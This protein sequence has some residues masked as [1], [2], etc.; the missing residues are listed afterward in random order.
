MGNLLHVC[1][2]NAD[3]DAAQELKSAIQSL[4]FVRLTAEV[5]SPEALA[6]AL[7]E[8][9][10]NLVFF[11]LD[12]DVAAVVEVIDQVSTRYP[13]LALIAISHE[14]GPEAILAPMRAGCDQ[15]VCEPIDPADLA[16][17]VG[18]VASKRLLSQPKSRCICLTGA[19]GGAGATSLA[20]NLALEIAHLT[21]KECALVDL[22]LQFGDV[23]INFDSEP[24]YTLY[25]LA[26]AGADLD[27]TILTSTLTKLP[28]KVALL[29]RPEMIE[30]HEAVT[31]D[32]IHRVI[33]LLT[34]NYENVIIDL[35]RHMDPCAAAALVHADLVLI[36]C[37]LLVPSVRNA[38]RYFNA[39]IQMG[40]PEERLQIVVNRGDSRA[41]GRLTV[42]DIEE[43]SRKP[44]YACIPNDYQFVARS[45]DFGRPIAALD[46]NSPVRA[47]IRKMARQITVGPGSEKREK[48][49]RRGF[50][51]R[52]LA[53]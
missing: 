35:P 22:D 51:S 9:T 16:T 21:D 42:K 33:E 23:A 18:R 50:L 29:S 17:A 49:A 20:C 25:D 38:K 39:L 52:L 53:K 28:C 37:Q 2:Y 3:P 5:S 24:K 8:A 44:V 19:S 4:N 47:A 48:S 45:I 31:P 32:A 43:T 27:H 36:V 26:A 14:T 1:L 6:A 46:R 41:G 15:F 34:A 12:P 30:Q 11:H 7:K 10:V 40:I 13:G